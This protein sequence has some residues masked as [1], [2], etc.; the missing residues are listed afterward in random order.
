MVES[1]P[2]LHTAG[3]ITTTIRGRRTMLIFTHRELQPGTDESVFTT[4][5]QPGGTRLGLAT[6]TREASGGWSVSGADA[7]VDDADAMHALLPL[8]QGPRPVL[9]YLHGN[10][11]TPAACFERCA[12]LERLYGLE[13]IGFS[14]ASEGFLADGSTLPAL[15]AAPLGGEGDLARVD[16]GNRTDAGIQNR[17]RRYKQAKTNAQD[18]VDALAR[19]LRM[20]GTARL[21]G[22]GQAFT[23]AAHSLGAHY[24]Q[25]V[26]DVDGAGESL[27]TAHN[28]VL[29][30]PCV[31]TAGHREWLAKL[32]PKGRAYVT[33]NKGDSVLFGAYVAD[34]Q[35]LKLGTDPGADLLVSPAVRYI[36]FSNSKTGFGGHAYFALDPMPKRSFKVFSRILGSR[37][38]LELDEYPRQIYPG[39]CLLD[40]STCYLGRPDSDEAP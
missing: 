3:T 7:D 19:F 6:V 33:Y 32:H 25:Y 31:R 12:L 11:N 40:G 23:L 17:I 16:V 9:L 28:V 36:D 38:D 34:G 8:F 39:G 20:V 13:V 18:A 2:R 27:G 30:A 4:R 24:L 15:A 37:P 1:P 22:N 5:F 10:N 21:Y 26:L 14:W 29:L 35:Q